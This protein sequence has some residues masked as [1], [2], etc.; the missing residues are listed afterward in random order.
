MNF[1]S[2]SIASKAKKMSISGI[3]HVLIGLVF[4][5][6][7]ASCMVGPN[8]R[9]PEPKI[10]ANW[11]ESDKTRVSDSLMEATQW[12]TIFNDPELNSLID[13]AIRSN[14]D[15]RLA[16]ARIRGARAARRVVAGA[17]YPGVDATADYSHSRQSQN[18]GNSTSAPVEHDLYQAGFDA[19]WEIDIFGGVRRAVE[20]ADAEVGASEENRRDVLVTLLAEVARNYLEVRGNQHRLAIARQNI[21]AQRQVV[22]LTHGRFE[23]GI[24]SAL[25]IAQAEGQLANTEAREPALESSIRQAI[26]RLGVLLGQEPGALLAELL[27]E[28]PIPTTPPEVPVGLPSQLL[29]RRPDIRRAERELASAT[30]RIGVATA[31]LFPRFSLTG[32]AGF[33]STNLTDLFGSGSGY[34]ILG[35]TV[36]WPIFNAGR[37]RANIEVQNALQE[38]ALIRYEKTIL[39]SLEEVENALVAYSKEQLSRR[40][41]AEAVDSSRKAADIANELYT[42]GLVNFLDVLDGERSLYQS[43][44]QLAQSDQRIAT[45]LIALFKALGGGW[46]IPR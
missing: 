32:L 27:K 19:G 46:E 18:T 10:P 23:A 26:H 11:S 7:L 37:I 38:Q 29:L 41:L 22:E 42:K 15:L 13:R 14:T 5:T 33:Q 17:E 31:D 45:D 28:A 21:Q 20:A 16:E 12:W 2:C 30:A 9:P 6:S 39:N 3:G 43:E 8:Y 36:R 4:M 25:D 1:P 24:G 35:P 44:D 40:A 34:W